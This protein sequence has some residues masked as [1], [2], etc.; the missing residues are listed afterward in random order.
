[1]TKVKAV[2]LQTARNGS[3]GVKNKNTLNVKGKPLFLHNLIHLNN[4]KLV[5]AVYFSTDIPEAKAYSE[6]FNYTVIDRPDYLA[7][8]DSSHYDAMKHGV[9]AILE[10]NDFEYLVITL[11]NS[12][13]AFP[14]DIDDCINFL[15]EHPEY[16]S[17]QSVAEHNWHTPLRA[18]RI[19]D[20]E[21]VSYITEHDS[22]NP[23]DRKSLGDIYF[24][25]GS[26][27]VIRKQVFL[28]Y[29][30]T[31]PFKWGGN[32]IKPFIQDQTF[33]ELDSNWQKIIFEKNDD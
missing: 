4:S 8:A 2:A 25:N 28:D 32:K 29:N 17:C 22:K 14:E 31:L 23:N 20:D 18:C 24:F 16:D 12:M 15:D 7:G 33:M 11:G 13:G 3:V 27:F 30:G 10:E 5:D 6:E 26:F 1:M 9:N 19:I 21:L